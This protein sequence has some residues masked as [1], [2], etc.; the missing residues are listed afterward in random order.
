MN[1]LFV[2]SNVIELKTFLLAAEAVAFPLPV[3]TAPTVAMLISSLPTWA[4]KLVTASLLLSTFHD[5][6]L[7]CQLED[8]LETMS[9]RAATL[10]VAAAAVIEIATTVL[11]RFII[12][13]SCQILELK[14]TL[15]AGLNCQSFPKTI[16]H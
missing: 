8:V 15:F 2:G 16:T 11:R 12:D 7:V 13:Y 3:S 14:M 5:V 10:N 9:A 6:L 4:V 1:T